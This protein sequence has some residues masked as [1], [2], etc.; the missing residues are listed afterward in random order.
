MLVR[1]VRDTQSFDAFIASNFGVMDAVIGDY[2]RQYDSICVHVRV[3]AILTRDVNKGHQRVAAYFSTRVHDVDRT[4]LLDLQRVTSNLWTS[5]P[6]ERSR[7]QLHPRSHLQ[8]H[9]VHFPHCPLHGYSYVPT[10]RWLAKK[11]VFIVKNTSDSK[12][13]VCS[14]LAVLHPGARNPNRL[15]NYKPYENTLDIFGLTFLLPCKT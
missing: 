8:V 12:C 5:L 13:F 9:L 3:D 7:Q 2:Q 6:L 1:T 11:Q 14:V 10:P 15:Y 4:Q